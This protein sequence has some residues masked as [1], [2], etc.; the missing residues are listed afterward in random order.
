MFASWIQRLFHRPARG[1]TQPRRQ[2]AARQSV[3]FH[4]TLEPLEERSLL[5]AAPAT[6]A[7]QAAY[8]QL[9]LAFTVNEGQAAPSINYVAQ[10]NGYSIALTALQAELNLSQGQ[11]SNTLDL[12]LVGA[13]AS[14]QAVGQNELITKSNYLLGNNQS[15]WLTNVANYGQVDYQNVYQGVDALYSGNQGQLETSFL[16]HPGANANVIQMQVQGADGLSL[17]AQGNLVIHTSGG[18]V[19]EQAP[20]MYQDINGTRQ[21]VTGHYVLEGNNTV[22]FQVG[23]YDPS[24]TLVIDPTLS[25][26]T[27]LNGSGNSGVGVAVAVDSS[28]DAYVVGTTTMGTLMPNTALGYGTFVDKLNAS[29]TALVYQTF[30]GTTTGL[31]GSNFGGSGIAVD[32]AG[33]AYVTG[34]ASSNFPTTANALQPTAP[35]SGRAGFVT[36]LDPTGANL[37]YSTYLPGAMTSAG[38]NY[39]AGPTVAISSA[40]VAPGNLDNIYVTG[41]A[42]T[43]LLTTASAFQANYTGSG[44]PQAFFAQINP[45]LSGAASLLYGSYLGGSGGGSGDAGTGIAVD[46]SGNAY[47]AGYSGSSNFPTTAGAFQ[48]TDPGGGPNAFVAKFNPSLSGSASLVYSTYLGGSSGS[49]GYYPRYPGYGVEQE[50][51]PGIAVDSSGDAYITGSTTS[52]NFPV[53]KRAFQTHLAKTTGNL[54]AACDAFVTKLNATGTGLVYSTYLGGNGTD[55]GSGIAVDSSGNAYATGWTWSTNFPTLNPI[56]SKNAGGSDA[57]E[58]TL[59]ATGSGLLSSTYLGGSGNDYGYGIALDSAGN[60]Y[61]TGQTTSTNFPT[62][63]GALQTSASNAFVF[64]IDPPAGGTSSPS[65]VIPSNSPATVN[66]GSPPGQGSNGQP[67]VSLTDQL[68]T[69]LGDNIGSTASQTDWQTL[70]AD[71]SSVD[72]ALLSRFEALWGAKAG[73]ANAA[74]ENWLRDLLFASL[75]S[76]NAV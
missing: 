66:A 63:A 8:G 36:V 40:G 44:L 32:A 9:P 29:G 49:S 53:T 70:L 50:T 61:V 6:A 3:W 52:T 69:L 64:K 57:F 55:G 28:G 51:G 31:N 65:G 26:S 18:D 14:A 16:V 41:E 4:P 56:Q 1:R 38:S 17:D 42:D 11:S 34:L 76:S 47:I 33:D 5:D 60:A 62:T 58:T 35:S 45:N 15:Q 30:L 25:Y 2:L 67:K 22:G 43:G 20:V 72:S 75:A 74:Q 24:Q 21:A 7:V 12:Q 59:N 71:W 48:A 13:N 37:L 54:T 39:I 10:G 73:I 23:T 27:Y 46:G 68:F 19:T